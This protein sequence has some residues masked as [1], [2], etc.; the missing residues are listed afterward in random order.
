MKNALLIGAG[1]IGKR[2]IR[3]FLKTGRVRLSICEPDEAKR[4]E[5]LRDYDIAESFADVADAPLDRFD[6]GV[7]CAPAHV[8]VPIATRLAEAGVP[9]LMEKPLSTG[10]D[11]VDALIETVN[12]KGLVVRIGYIR[13]ATEWIRR[14][15]EDVLDGRIGELRMARIFSGQ[16]YR[17]YRPDYARIYYARRA[18]GGGA[19]LDAASHSVDLLLWIMGP[20][21]EVSAFYD[22]LQF[23][24]ECE[25]EDTCLINLRFRSGALAQLTVVQF[26]QP[27]ES[28][29]EFAGDK[30]NLRV[31]DSKGQLLYADDD[32]GHWEV[33]SFIDEGLAPMEVHEARFAVQANTYLDALEGKPDC[34]ATLGEARENL[35][36]CLAAL[37][38][39]REK[40]VVQL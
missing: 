15:R 36:V 24:P 40:R 3:G 30:A 21:A 22:K 9:F 8:H 31:N 19:I 2:H 28:L 7:I 29:V 5:V 16:D 35:A 34:L 12:A 27:L 26:Q 39:D 18:T 25:C 33:E 14:L 38:S 1:G 23:G 17:I 32:S 10:M 11:G 13:R 4:E 20:V 6:L 37:Q